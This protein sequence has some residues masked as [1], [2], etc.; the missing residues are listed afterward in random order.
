[1]G[2]PALTAAQ[3]I[4]YFD[5]ISSSVE[6]LIMSSSEATNVTGFNKSKE[7]FIWFIK[8]AM[9]DK[10]SDAYAELYHCLI[11]MFVDVD[12]N[13]DG[14]VSRGSF[15]KLIDMAAPIQRMYGYAPTDAELYKTEDEKD[16]ARQ[17]MF[18]SMDLK[19]TGVITVDEWL[20]FCMEHII[21]KTATLAAH[22]ILD[23]GSLEQFSAFVKA[24]VV[25][26]SA[27]NTEL[28]WFLL[29]LFT[30]ADPDK[31]GIVMSSDF[32]RMLDRALETPKKLGMNHPDENLM[33][34]DD[35]KRKECHHA[36]FK[37]YNPV[38]DDKMCFDEWIKL[39]V[40]GV[41]KKMVA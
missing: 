21:A 30:E 34:T 39:A 7:D 41:F 3:I 33:A 32:S 25:I 12:T 29:E 1:M 22:P 11:K 10:N 19:G 37:A 2:R 15:S 4:I 26:G 36:M 20:K 40:E 14:L 16:K 24:A 27:E 6:G 9:K 13:R 28:Y 31:D 38:G 5:L 17:K 23:H 8:R 35:A 18:M